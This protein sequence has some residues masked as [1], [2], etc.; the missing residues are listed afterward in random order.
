MDENTIIDGLAVGTRALLAA[1]DYAE[2]ME[3]LE[4]GLYGTMPIN[5]V[6]TP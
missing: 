1:F 4:L 5:T 2:E 3:N 6:D